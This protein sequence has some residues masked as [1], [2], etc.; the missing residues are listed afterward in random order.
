MDG[1]KSGVER[2]KEEVMSE[3]L[4]YYDGKGNAFP[5]VQRVRVMPAREKCWYKAWQDG[6]VYWKA[7]HLR[8]WGQSFIELAAGGAGA[9]TTAVVEDA[10]TSSVLEVDPSSVSFASEM[11][12]STSSGIRMDRSAD[13]R[14]FRDNDKVCCSCMYCHRHLYYEQD[15]NVGRGVFNA[16]CD[17]VCEDLYSATL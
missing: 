6:M 10:K 5:L 9:I 7:G 16:F 3:A 14:I 4:I 11:P 12:G 8:S 1:K 2:L 13:P 15:S 17:D